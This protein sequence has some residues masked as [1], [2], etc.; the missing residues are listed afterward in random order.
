MGEAA[1]KLKDADRVLD[2]STVRRWSSGLDCF[3][4]A[5]SFVRQITACVARWLQ[6]GN[7][8]G[9][10]AAP[11]PWMASALEILWPMRL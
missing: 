6:R 1:P 7:P 9:P 5:V 10:Q 8:N 4:P 11:L 2:A 3:E